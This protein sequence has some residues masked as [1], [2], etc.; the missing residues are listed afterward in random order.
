M[1][2]MVIERFAPNGLDAVHERFTRLG[3]LLP[4]DVVYHAS[5]FG[6]DGSR[7]FQI[8][9]APDRDSID[10]WIDRWK[11]IV[12]FEVVSV[13]PSTAFWEART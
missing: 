12:E 4:D 10:D 5:W 7:C 2:F 11:D 9:E 3:R 1:L 8:M 13:L 6:A